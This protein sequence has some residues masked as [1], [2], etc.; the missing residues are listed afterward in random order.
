[1]R[2]K[3]SKL[4]KTILKTKTKKVMT[5]QERKINQAFTELESWMKTLRN[6]LETTGSLDEKQL[7]RLIEVRDTAKRI[8]PPIIEKP[9]PYDLPPT[10]SPYEMAVN[11][12]IHRLDKKR[13]I[14]SLQYKE[15]Y[16]KI[17]KKYEEEHRTGI[18][19]SSYELGFLRE[20]FIK[21]FYQWK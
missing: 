18:N 13:D 11:E 9:N 5:D 15:P 7:K 17:R 12:L 14:M 8:N 16:D 1:M 3:I 19:I 6:Q 2:M 20:L 21:L 4:I 10:K